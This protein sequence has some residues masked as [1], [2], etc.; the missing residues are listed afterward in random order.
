MRA[1]L[2]AVLQGLSARAPD[3]EWVLVILTVS[4]AALSAFSVW[5]ATSHADRAS[6]LRNQERVAAA[7][8]S[9]ELAA[10]SVRLDHDLRLVTPYCAAVTERGWGMLDAFDDSA[11]EEATGQLA[12]AS[13][14]A[15]LI[16]SLFQEAR[17]PDC[18]PGP[19]PA[20]VPAAYEWFAASARG[21]GSRRGPT[22][23]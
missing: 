17:L 5:Q 23:P 15:I 8:R 1:S 21:S 19:A 4:A 16:G 2:G 18:Q 11:D 14:R 9:E 6:D 12:N 3:R 7:R 10:F 13:R 20:L 22:R